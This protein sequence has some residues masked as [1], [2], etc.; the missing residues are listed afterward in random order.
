[1]V[2]KFEKFI[3][4]V[5]VILSIVCIGLN[6]MNRNEIISTVSNNTSNETKLVNS[7]NYIKAGV[8]KMSLSSPK[9]VKILVNGE[10]N[11]N[12]TL[13]DNIMTLAVKNKDVVEIDLR[14]Y[15]E[16]ELN[17]LIL[18]VSENI[19]NP[20]NGKKYTFTKGINKLFDVKIE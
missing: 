6:I 2:Y 5:I 10:E 15:K 1:M 11:F 14:R 16:E 17:V 9:N 7:S 19:K 13:K 8:V 12:Y 3:V 20:L 18:K 4:S